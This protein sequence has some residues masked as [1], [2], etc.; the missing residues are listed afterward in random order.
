[1]LVAPITHMSTVDY[2]GKLCAVVFLGGCNLRC[3]YC[4]NRRLVMGEDCSE[5][6]A[7]DVVAELARSADFLDAVTVTGGEPLLQDVRPLLEGVKGLG[8]LAKLDTNGTLPDRLEGV[9]DLLDYVAIDVKAPLDQARYEAVVGIP[10]PGV[11]DLVRRSKELVRARGR[12]LEAR[13]TVLPR[14]HEPGDVASIAR[15]IRADRL[16]VQQFRAHMG[17]LDPSFADARPFTRDEM[18]A[19]AR[20]AAACFGGEVYAR[21]AERGLERVTAQKG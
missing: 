14:L 15:A 16:T 9:L 6:T 10:F 21:T 20:E 8:L 1:L 17:T 5:R 13:T 18:L 11:V 7:D 4:Q 3:P 19:M 2:P 12:Y